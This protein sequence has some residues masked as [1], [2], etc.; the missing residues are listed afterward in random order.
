MYVLN[1]TNVNFKYR[2]SEWT[3][4]LLDI[5]RNTDIIVQDTKRPMQDTKWDPNTFPK[6]TVHVVNMSTTFKEHPSKQRQWDSQG[7]KF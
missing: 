5:K 6:N 7:C 4:W 2:T 1:F 3:V